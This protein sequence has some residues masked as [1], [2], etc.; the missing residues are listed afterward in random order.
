MSNGE[1]SRQREDGMRFHPFLI[2]ESITK[3]VRSIE[4]YYRKVNPYYTTIK[5]SNEDDFIVTGFM[6][7][8]AQQQVIWKIGKNV[9][10]VTV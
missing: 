2:S 10:K 9:Y 6:F 1:R 3:S 7:Y 4:I 5:T 8:D